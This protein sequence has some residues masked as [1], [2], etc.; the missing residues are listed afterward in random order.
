MK[1]FTVRTL[2]VSYTTA[3]SN[4]LA[5]SASGRLLTVPSKSKNTSS[6][7]WSTPFQPRVWWMQTSWTNSFDSVPLAS[8]ANWN[9]PFPWMDTISLL[10][11]T[12]FLEKRVSKYTKSGVNTTSNDWSSMQTYMFPEAATMLHRSFAFHTHTCLMHGSHAS[13]EALQDLLELISYNATWT[14]LFG[15]NAVCVSAILLHAQPTSVE[16][17][18]SA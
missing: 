7:K 1:L 2:P 12:N 15:P 9:N 5:L 8:S 11:K 6:A 17:Q 18:R 16:S 4:L 3:C 13:S 14:N 10:G